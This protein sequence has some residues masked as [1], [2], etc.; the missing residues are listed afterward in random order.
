MKN[1]FYN[2]LHTFPFLEKKNLGL[3]ILAISGNEYFP[4]DFL[5]QKILQDF[6]ML[7]FDPKHFSR[8][9]NTII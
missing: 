4:L 3:T 9:K 1:D 5:S 7:T 6:H 2:I 8:V